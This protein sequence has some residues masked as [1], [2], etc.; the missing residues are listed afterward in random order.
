[1]EYITK[2]GWVDAHD[3]SNKSTLFICPAVELELDTFKNTVMGTYTARVWLNFPDGSYRYLTTLNISMRRVYQS[4]Q[5]VVYQAGFN[6]LSELITNNDPKLF[7]LIKVCLHRR[8]A[9]E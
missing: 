6:L 1:M 2:D 8:Y 7:K 5:S 9:Q 4:C 3:P